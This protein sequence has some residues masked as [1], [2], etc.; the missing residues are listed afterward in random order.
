MPGKCECMSKTHGHIGRCRTTIV[1]ARRG[2]QG[3]GGWEAHHIK[4][5]GGT[6]LSNCEI[7]CM[8]CLSKAKD[9][10]A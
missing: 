4:A 6:D 9:Q 1:P 10:Q 3:Q 2:Y 7:L 8:E 5:D